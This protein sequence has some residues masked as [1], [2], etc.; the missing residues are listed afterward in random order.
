MI[1]KAVKRAIDMRESKSTSQLQATTQSLLQRVKN[2]NQH[3]FSTYLTHLG[4]NTEEQIEKNKPAMAWAK[5]R[6]EK[7]ENQQN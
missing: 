2:I 6:L 1:P 4:K 7:M 3:K 5:A